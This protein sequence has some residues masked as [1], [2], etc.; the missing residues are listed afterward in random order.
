[1]NAPRE[2]RGCRRTSIRH[3]RALLSDERGT[4]TA[5]F[6]IVLPAVLVVLGLVLGG[7]LI[8]SH[9]A[10]LVST[11]AEV[12]RLEARGDA[13]LAAARIASVG[14]SVEVRR[15]HRGRLSC[16]S[17]RSHPGGGLL[18]GIGIEAE[19]CAVGD[20]AGNTP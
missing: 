17:L 15:E 16:I 12:A 10:T 19:A 4:V 5:E 6:A 1:M 3:L 13:A 11:A 8:A 2:R 9:R 18:S 20:D 14:G 7:I